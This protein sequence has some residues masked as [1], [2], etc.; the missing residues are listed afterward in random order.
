MTPPRPTYSAV[1]SSRPWPLSLDRRWPNRGAA[2]RQVILHVAFFRV[3]KFLLFR[4]REIF[5]GI[6]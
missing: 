4:V 5:L 6:K 2:Q 1:S 3:R